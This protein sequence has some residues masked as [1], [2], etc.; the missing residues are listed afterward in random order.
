[1]GMRNGVK[2]MTGSVPMITL[3]GIPEFCPKIIF[4][5]LAIQNASKLWEILF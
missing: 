1:M 2:N 4:C 3:F 5:P